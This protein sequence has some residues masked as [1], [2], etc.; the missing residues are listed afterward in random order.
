MISGIPSRELTYPQKWHFED[1]FP[2]PKVG[3]VNS[4]EGILL[5]HYIYVDALYYC[6]LTCPQKISSNDAP[7]VPEV[8]HLRRGTVP[9]TIA[10]PGCDS[11]TGRGVGVP[12]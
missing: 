7:P 6:I 12:T 9:F 1:E 5:Y 3:Y 10:R 2:F 8:Y 4:L 11:T